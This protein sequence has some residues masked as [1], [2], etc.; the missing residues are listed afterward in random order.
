MTVEYPNNFTLND[1]N[2][3]FLWRYIDLPKLL[4]LLNNKR[5]YFSR[6]DHF[7]D[8]LEGITGKGIT[9]KAFTQA[10]PL[11]TEN[12][13]KNLDE[14]TQEN[15]ITQ[16]KS[17]RERYLDYLVKS[18][19]TQFASCW[20]LG[21][22]ESLAMWKIYSK[23]EGV[24]VKFN[25][26]ELIENVVASA[27]SY[28]NTDFSRFYLGAVTYKNI[29]PFDPHEKFDQKFNGLKKDNSYSHENEFRFVTVV[30]TDK[31]GLYSKF[32]LPIAEL[33][34]LNVKVIANPFMES[35]EIENL[36]VLLAKYNL[37]NCFTPSE[38]EI[39]KRL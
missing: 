6:F 1:Y 13:N 37:A 15:L 3:R 16:D 9:L 23:K 38:M 25:A 33:S 34:A 27:E 35:Y 26:K 12:V 7:E 11:T 19:Q 29:W 39:R 14:E 8:G 20:F 36:K 28:T 31:K 2:D 18:Q 22:R 30:P 24:A 21:N 4:D 32:I 10:A 5:L 17:M